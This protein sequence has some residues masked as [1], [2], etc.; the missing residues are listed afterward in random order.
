VLF[1]SNDITNVPVNTARAN[2]NTEYKA[3]EE[4]L[5]KLTINVHGAVLQMLSAAFQVRQEEMKNAIQEH[6][7][8]AQWEAQ[9]KQA[10]ADAALAAQQAEIEA[11]NRPKLV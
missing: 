5:A 2:L 11:A 4:R 9:Q 10:A 7:Q 8:R 6:Q 1:R 3:I